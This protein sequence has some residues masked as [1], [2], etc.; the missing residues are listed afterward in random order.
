[1]LPWVRSTE[2]PQVYLAFH[3]LHRTGAADLTKGLQKTSRLLAEV[4]EGEL[5]VT[6]VVGV[7]LDFLYSLFFLGLN[8]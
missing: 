8:I 6:A 2:H 7:L 5:A 4:R 3:L 1:M